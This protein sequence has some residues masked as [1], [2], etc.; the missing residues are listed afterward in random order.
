MSDAPKPTP[1]ITLIPAGRAWTKRCPTQKTTAS[2]VQPFRRHL[3][4]VITLAEAAGA[5]VVILATSRPYARAW[6]MHYAWRIDQQ[7]LD[8]AVVPVFDGPGGLAEVPIAWTREGA[9]EMVEA[10]DLVYRPSLTSH[11]IP[12]AEGAGVHASD[13]TVHFPHAVTLVDANGAQVAIAAG[14]GDTDPAFWA[15]ART[16]GV[17]KL[18]KDVGHWSDDG[19]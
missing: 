19:H 5:V 15:F 3:Q 11:H 12:H 18:E 2:L 4:Q 7:G 13:M 1:P 17:L 14:E 8:P 9:R 10:Y 6:L 16:F